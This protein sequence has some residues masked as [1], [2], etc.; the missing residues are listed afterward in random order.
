MLQAVSNVADLQRLAIA[1]RVIEEQ[2]P[3]TRF[4][5]L[6]Q[7]LAG[8]EG[9][10]HYQLRFKL[11]AAGQPAVH[12]RA[13]ANVPLLCQRTLETYQHVLDVETRLGA[14]SREEDEAALLS[15]YEPLL[16]DGNPKSF[17]QIAEDEL[18][19]AL[20]LVPLK[21][22]SEGAIRAWEAE[23]EVEEPKPAPF[24]A[25]AKWKKN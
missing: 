19:L 20:P 14:I 25:L 16:L 23:P 6:L 9:Q 18:I 8:T 5:R 4:P 10:V 11:N 22:G 7:S 2:Q 15:G 3:L 17:D 21:P 24:A 12:V 1:E 13:Q